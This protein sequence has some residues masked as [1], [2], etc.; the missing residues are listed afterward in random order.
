MARPKTLKTCTYCAKEVYRLAGHGLCANCY[1][2]E[3]RNGTPTYVKIRKPCSV[4]GCDVLAVAQGYCE[5]HY[6]R[7]KRHGVAENERFDRWGHVSKHPL[8]Q[9]YY[10]LRSKQGVAFPPE[11][12]DFWQFARDVGDRPSPRHKLSSID[13]TKPIGPGNVEWRP[14]KFDISPRDDPAAYARLMVASRPRERKASTL[15]KLYGINIEQYE[16]ML[17]AQDGKCALCG[18]PETTPHKATGLPRDMAVD[19]CHK[20]G[21]VRALLCAACNGGLGN[22]RDDPMLLERAAAYLRQHASHAS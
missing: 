19:H 6:R 16:A 18:S 10:W 4:D 1:Y 15:K 22:F 14:P 7:W 13:K 17:V 3:K 11:W 8:A 9:S 12:R 2:R 21:K 5:T 20:T